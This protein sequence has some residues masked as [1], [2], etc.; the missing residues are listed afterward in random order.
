V[1]SCF[2]V[3]D[4]KKDYW[5]DSGAS[6]HIVNSNESLIEVESVKRNLSGVFG[7]SVVVSQK[8]SIELKGEREFKKML[9]SI[10]KPN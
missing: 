6:K 10:Q 5:L 8:G 2:N 7:D 9:C 3:I 4:E 1:D